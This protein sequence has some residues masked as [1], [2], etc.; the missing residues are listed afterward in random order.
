MYPI[1]TELGLNEEGKMQYEIFG[2]KLKELR[3]IS[4]TLKSLKMQGLLDRPL[5]KGIICENVRDSIIT[6]NDSRRYLELTGKEFCWATVD[7]QEVKKYF[8]EV[9]SVMKYIDPWKYPHIHDIYGEILEVSQK[10]FSG[11]DRHYDTIR[12]SRELLAILKAFHT[13]G[14]E[15]HQA[16]PSRISKRNKPL[17]KYR[18]D[19]LSNTSIARRNAMMLMLLTGETTYITLDGE[20]KPIIVDGFIRGKIDWEQKKPVQSKR[21]PKYGDVNPIINSV[22][23]TDNPLID[24]VAKYKLHC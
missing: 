19:S 6:E 4:S 3:D 10:Y 1:A 14:F 24:D 16:T 5:F 23:Y 21:T 2:V 13:I 12:I 22:I 18:F 15:M 7:F 17:P 8:I 9:T 11:I 20:R